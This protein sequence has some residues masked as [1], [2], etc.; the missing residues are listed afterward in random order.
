[1]V[2]KKIYGHDL[3]SGNIFLKPDLQG[4]PVLHE[5]YNTSKRLFVQIEAEYE[6]TTYK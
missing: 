4:R 1:M 5:D 3:E 6:K 2:G